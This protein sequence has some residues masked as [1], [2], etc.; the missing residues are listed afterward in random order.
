MRIT[1]NM[2]S[3]KYKNS[4]G[5]TLAGMLQAGDRVN[6]QQ[7]LLKPEQNATAYVSAYNVQRTIDDLTQFKENGES[8]TGWVS[9]SEK[10]LTDALEKLK[11]V[12]ADF[13]IGGANATNDAESR[14]AMAQQVAV[15]MDELMSLANNS[16]LGRHIFGGFQTDKPPFSGSGSSVSN[17]SSN[18][19]G[20]TSI[21]TKPVFSDMGELDSGSYRTDISVVN[22]IATVSIFDSNGK[23][24]VLDSNGSDEA[25]QKGNSTSNTLSFKYEPGK[26]VNTGLGFSVQMPNKELV[27][28]QITVEFDYR[29]GSEVSYA[30]DMESILAQIGYDQNIAI[31][32]PGSDIFMQAYKTLLSTKVLTANGSLAN[33][34]TLLADLDGNKFATGDSMNISGTD[35]HGRP[36]GSANIVSPIDPELNHTNTTEEERTLKVAYG[37]KMYQV[38]IPQGNYNSSEKLAE[39]VQKELKNAEFIGSINVPA[40]GYNELNDFQNSIEQQIDNG[41]FT[42]ATGDEKKKTVDLSEDVSVTSDGDRLSFYTNKGGDNVQLAISGADGSSLGFTNSVTVAEGKDTQFD[43]G[44]TY[45]NNGIESISTS[46]S[47]IDFSVGG[48]FDFMING[49]PVS[50]HLPA[51]GPVTTTDV[52]ATTAYNGT[53]DFNITIDGKNV[54]VPAAQLV[55]K[56]VAEQEKII[57]QKMIDSGFGG[58]NSISL[59]VNPAGTYTVNLNSATAPTKKD[60]EFELQA[61]LNSA[62]FTGDISASLSSVNSSNPDDLGKFNLSFAVVNNNINDSTQINTVYFDNSVTPPFKDMQTDIPTIKQ[63]PG[64]NNTTMGDYMNFLNDLYGET[65]TVSLVNGKIQVKDMRSGGDS[66]LT[67]F[68]NSTESGLQSNSDNDLVIGGKYRGQ[69]DATWGVDMTTTVGADGSRN[70]HISIKDI[71]G[72]E[73]YN[74]RVSNYLGGEIALPSGVTITPNENQFPTPPETS[75]TTSFDLDLIDDTKVSLGVMKVSDDGSNDNMFRVLKNLEHALKYNILKNGFALNNPDKP[76]Q[77]PSLGSSAIPYF[78]G[79]YKGNYNDNWNYEVMQN[80]SKDDFYIQ[81]ESYSMS[82]ATAF[83]Q[84]LINDL[85]SEISFGINMYDNVTGKSSTVNIDLDLSKAFPPLTDAKSTNAYIVKELNNNPELKKQGVTFAT[86]VTTSGEIKIKMDSNNGTKIVSFAENIGAMPANSDKNALSNYIMGFEALNNEPL[87][88]TSFPLTL[89]DT[90]FFITDIGDTLN[91][92][93]QITL[94]APAT[95]ATKAD[96]LT[97]VNTELATATANRVIASYDSTGELV[98]KKKG[99]DGLPT[100]PA[101]QAYGNDELGI[102]TS[103]TGTIVAAK[104]P[105]LADTALGESSDEARTLTFNYI[106]DLGVQRT[107]S[108]LLDKKDYESHTALT[109]EINKLIA[110]DPDLAGLQAKLGSDKRISFTTTEP[111]NINNL[112]V[113]NDYD[114]TLGFP[115]AGDQT[116][117][118]VTSENGG[119]IQEIPVNTADEFMSVADGLNLAFNKGKISASDSFDA[120]IGTGIDGQIDYID[121]IEKQLLKAVAEV[122]SRLSRVES[123]TVFHTT[124]IGANETTKSTY[125]GSTPQDIAKAMTD[126]ALAT[127]AYEMSL[128]ITSNMLNISLIDFLR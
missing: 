62:G 113:E 90:D 36:I 33:L 47:N 86:D 57:N 44:T 20:S 31:N 88:D 58:S 13:A 52:S 40:G 122:G 61:A 8:A 70:V 46:H 87:P 50:V 66:E 83:D 98:F 80:G 89:T 49:E 124:V 30:G 65:A 117:I 118:R 68:Q 43:F 10:I 27:N 78:D 111:T 59:A 56:T 79:T 84:T 25:N 75:L 7:N 74:Q 92:S 67:F 23:P 114:G 64:Q 17:V 106:D 14:A 125:L 63:T 24:V 112:S 128:K 99:A 2:M 54:K 121:Q 95:Y 101:I 127:A 15:I 16:Y 60:I 26:V 85:G 123:V 104:P 28:T 97:A 81:N 35:S 96:L 32:T 119:I 37:N 94:P 120:A 115:K 91:P 73:V 71:N 1:F 4:I 18:M 5:T 55:G 19:L 116:T 12:K 22:G 108:I 53:N 48:K 3:M 45:N 103:D 72:L 9:N 107:K 109:E 51:R 34:A 6:A 69:G 105:Q 82:G 102:S 21:A 76:W 77:N 38:V 11:K 100:G 29:A 126:Q 110:L 93:K 42:P 41:Y 39:A